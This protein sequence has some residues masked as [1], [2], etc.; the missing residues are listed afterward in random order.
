MYAYNLYR[1]RSFT[2]EELVK[3]FGAATEQAKLLFCYQKARKLVQKKDRVIHGWKVS[4]FWPLSMEQALKSARA[5]NSFT[6][7][8]LPLFQRHENT[9]RGLRLSLLNQYKANRAGT[10]P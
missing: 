4:G 1:Y 10:S 5:R 9:F 8:K 3:S 7:I 2:D 6:E